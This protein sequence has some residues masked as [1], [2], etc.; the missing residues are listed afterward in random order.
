ME[1]TLKVGKRTN[2]AE[3]RAYTLKSEKN[4]KPHR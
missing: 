1:E 3:N 2:T 4:I